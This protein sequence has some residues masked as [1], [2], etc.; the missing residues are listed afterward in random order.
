MVLDLLELDVEHHQQ[1]GL[2]LELPKREELETLAAVRKSV[3]DL[4]SILQV[5]RNEIEKRLIPS[6]QTWEQYALAIPKNIKLADVLKDKS[7]GENPVLRAVIG[8]SATRPQL[9]KLVN[10]V[11]RVKDY[12]E[13]KQG[14]STKTQRYLDIL[15]AFLKD[16]GK[17]LAFGDEGD[18]NFAMEDN[19]GLRPV[20]SLSSG[21]AQLFVIMTHL[22]FN[23]AAQAG[24]VLIIDEPELSLHIQWQEL[25]VSSVI[26]ANPNVQYLMATHSPSIILDRLDK[27]CDLSKERT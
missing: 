21:E 23:P 18:L 15:N 10:M 3:D 8:W 16:S 24:N 6:L 7:A 14:L 1:R 27:C 5:P 19:P 11:A 25:F 20:S 12:T 4:P 22:F 9:R 26:A 17:H 13:R 2:A